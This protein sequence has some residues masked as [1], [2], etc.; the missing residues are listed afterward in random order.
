LARTRFQASRFFSDD[1]FDNARVEDMY[2]A[3]LA[4]GLRED[5]GWVTLVTLDEL[6]F[7]VCELR[8]PTCEGLISLIA[9]APEVEGRGIGG[10]LVEGAGKI[11]AE[12]SMRTAKV[13]TQGSNIAAQR[14]YHAHGYRTTRV[15]FWLH[16][17]RAGQ[18]AYVNRRCPA[19]HHTKLAIPP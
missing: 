8:K 16:W 18:R 12:S 15:S 10:S 1:G 6:G 4:R 17:W 19:V 13:I 9:V 3:W 5:D 14:L 7:I 11:F 2:A